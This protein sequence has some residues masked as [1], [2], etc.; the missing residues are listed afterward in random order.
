MTSLFKYIITPK[1]GRYNNTVEIDGNELIVNTDIFNHKHISR[2][3]IVLSVPT[4]FNSPIKEGMEVIVHHNIF[5]RW[6]DIR[7]VEKDSSS[8][9]DEDKY[10]CYIDQVYMYKEDGEWKGIENYCFV[11]PVVNDDDFVIQNEKKHIGIV[12]VGNK[13]LELLGIKVGDVVGFTPSSEYEFIV[14]GQLMYRM[15]YEDICI[16]YPKDSYKKYTPKL[17]ELDA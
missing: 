13:Y 6:H 12:E 4:A 15:S 8:Y 9:I 14:D 10:S 16:K 17:A 2:E 5:R 7:G 11:A 3:A 1:G